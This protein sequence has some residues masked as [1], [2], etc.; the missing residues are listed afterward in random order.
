MLSKSKRIVAS[1]AASISLVLGVGV[2]VSQ[3]N[4]ESIRGSATGARVENGKI[5]FVAENKSVSGTTIT[6]TGHTETGYPIIC[7]IENSSGTVASDAIGNF[8]NGTTANFYTSDGTTQFTF[9]N[10]N[11]FYIKKKTG[12]NTQ[13][14]FRL[15]YTTKG[16][17]KSSSYTS[18]SDDLATKTLNFTGSSYVGTTDLIMTCTSG[19][20]YLSE[21]TELGFDYTCDNRVLERIAVTTAPSK[22][23]YYVGEVFNSSGIVVTGYYDNGDAIDVTDECTFS[24]SKMTLST[25]EVIITYGDLSTTQAVTVSEPSYPG[26]YRYTASSYVYLINLYGEEGD[27]EGNGLYTFT[28]NNTDYTMHFLWSVEN[29]VITFT[30]DMQSGDSYYDPGYGFYNLFAQSGSYA[31]TNTGT[32]AGTSIQNVYTCSTTTNTTTKK[33]FSRIG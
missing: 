12:T 19:S 11:H 30:K 29:S 10:I 13:L 4:I 3:V 5:S 16:V 6:I 18:F 21:V 28:Y 31:D 27:K 15:N 14:N 33:T 7:K 9:Q 2:F 25:T 8:V 1:L 32:F 24:S 17:A 22:T 23:N 20:G 26:T